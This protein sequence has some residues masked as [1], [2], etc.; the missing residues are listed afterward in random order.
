MTPDVDV[1]GAQLYLGDCLP[2]LAS[3]ETGS[4]YLILT[5]PPY[6][7]S[8]TGVGGRA[9]TKIGKVKTKTGHRSVR[10]DFGAWD[11]E[12]DPRPFLAEAARVL[13]T[14]GALVSFVSEF[15]LPAFVASELDHRS[16]LYWHKTNPTPSFR[17]FPQRA[18]EQIVWQTRGGHWTFRRGG[19][20]PNL[21]EA[22]TAGSGERYTRLDDE[23]GAMVTLHPTQ[24]PITLMRELVDVFS[25]P[26]GLI[27]DPYMG[28]GTTVRAAL[29]LGRRAI[30]C[31]LDPL[32]FPVAAVRASQTV[33]PML[34]FGFPGSPILVLARELWDQ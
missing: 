14:G 13:R 30:G 27:L 33:M 26:G 16:M 15:T 31:E 5:G 20:W 29:D 18:V 25:E 8:A 6:N 7:V 1:N 10:R 11:Y 4:V 24:K 19:A 3:L 23:T 22:P 9:N 2:V 28:T 32:Y 34:D 12:W 21:I 17:G